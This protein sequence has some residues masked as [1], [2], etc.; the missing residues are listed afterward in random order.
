MKFSEMNYTRPDLSKVQDD[1]KK[2]LTKFSEA[3]TAAEQKEALSQ[4][5]TLKNEFNTY[6]SIA[7]VRNSINTKDSYYETEQDFFDANQPVMKDLD[8]KFYKALGSSRFKPELEKKFGRQLFKLV[9]VELKTFDASIIDDL[10]EENKLG[11]EYTKLVA[12]AEIEFNGQKLTLPAL[13]AFME[14]TDREVRKKAYL[15]N[16]G[17]F[18][19]HEKEFDEIFDKLVKL[20]TRIAHKLGYKNFVELGYNRMLRTDYD[21]KMVAVFRDEVLKHVVPLAAKL[22]ERQRVRIG[23]DKLKAYDMSHNFNSG[24]PTPKG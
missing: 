19:L 11:T 1:F 18:A 20:R 24:N 15:A 12:S 13:S 8:M 22:R 14:S 21:A 2:L 7:S 10:K 6:A 16:H 5:N 17:W 23:V 4:I 9:D 3:Q